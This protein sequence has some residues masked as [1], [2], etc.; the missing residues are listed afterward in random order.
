[1]KSKKYSIW[2]VGGALAMPKAS[3]PLTIKMQD[4][5]GNGTSKSGDINKPGVWVWYVV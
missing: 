4:A 2:T 3:A 5:A 1:M